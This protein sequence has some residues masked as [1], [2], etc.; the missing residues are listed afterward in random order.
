M[1]HGGGRGD[2]IRQRSA[3]GRQETAGQRNDGEQVKQVASGGY[4][5]TINNDLKLNGVAVFRRGNDG[6]LI[7]VSG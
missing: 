5:Y 2:P 4:L 6:G 3:A 7:E 1:G